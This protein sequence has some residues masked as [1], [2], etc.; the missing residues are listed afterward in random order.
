MD[1]NSSE[2]T[3]QED[4]QGPTADS[5]PDEQITDQDK[6][7]GLLAYVIALIV[8]LIILLSETG[9]QSRF[10]RFHA[11]QSLVLSGVLL[12]AGL[13]LCCPVAVVAALT[14]GI[15]GVCFLPIILVEFGL[16][17]Y[18]GI[19]AYQGEY[20]TIPYL[21]DFARNSGWL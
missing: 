13:V 1:E 3:P 16:H 9:K 12:I 8:P 17:I 19:K 10:Q 15:G 6:M 4:L 11:V 20:C 7:M 2:I 18:Y 5:V 14:A 21:T